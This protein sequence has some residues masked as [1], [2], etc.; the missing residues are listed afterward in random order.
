MEKQQTL[1]PGVRLICADAIGAMMARYGYTKREAI[2]AVRVFLKNA[3]TPKKKG[4]AR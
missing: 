1:Y 4:A 2:E 3:D